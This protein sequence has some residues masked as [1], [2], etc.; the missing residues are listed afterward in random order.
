[1]CAGI[2]FTPNPR[3]LGS[4]QL[5]QRPYQ[6]RCN[7]KDHNRSEQAGFNER[8]VSF[9]HSISLR[10]QTLIKCSLKALFGTIKQPIPTD[11]RLYS[12][13]IMTQSSESSDAHQDSRKAKHRYLC[14]SYGL[15]NN[16]FSE[17]QSF[18]AM[19]MCADDSC[20]CIHWSYPS[21]GIFGTSNQLS[22]RI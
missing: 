14:I 19:W 11:K 7:D 15:H 3:Y 16:R 10:E 18:H 13:K 4:K 12:L 8:V 6:P 17:D 5:R 21:I 20:H 1:M 9:L 2:V 22:A